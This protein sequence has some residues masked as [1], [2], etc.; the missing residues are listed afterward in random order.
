MSRFRGRL[1]S[2]SLILSLLALFVALGG[3]TYA[4][5]ALP[6]HSV[7][8]AQLRERS[9]STDKLRKHA[10]TQLRLALNSVAAGRVINNSL[11]GADINEAKLG[12]VPNAAKLG[13]TPATGYQKATRW[14]L[15][16][17][18]AAG[19]KI[20]AQSGGMTVQRAGAGTYFVNTGAS[21][22]S[23]PLSVSLSRVGA[24]G[25]GSAIV[26]PCGGPT[27][28]PGGINCAQQNTTSVVSV[29]TFDTGSTG[30]TLADKTF[31]VEIG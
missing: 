21:A 7:G 5:T 23:Q 28:N 6:A 25:G 19:A 22:A 3:T 16:Q 18:T 8:N 1:P 26:A 24:S 29:R 14:A 30:S 11:T 2:P 13:G 20:L 12:T 31:Y 15:V 10:V 17:G 27:G 9:V 4:A